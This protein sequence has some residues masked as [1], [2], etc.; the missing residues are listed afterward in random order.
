MEPFLL[1]MYKWTGE[2]L[3]CSECFYWSTEV[4]TG[5]DGSLLVDLS[6]V[7]VSTTQPWHQQLPAKLFFL[8]ILRKRILCCAFFSSAAEVAVQVRSSSD[9]AKKLKQTSDMD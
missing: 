6:L 7:I 8:R 3:T 1:K 5:V 9:L 4:L 2:F